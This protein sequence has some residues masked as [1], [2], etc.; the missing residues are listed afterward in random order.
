M[1]CVRE[2][3]SPYD[4]TVSDTLPGNTISHTQGV[5]AG[6]P[7]N[8]GYSSN[9]IAGIAPGQSRSSAAPIIRCASA[10]VGRTL[11]FSE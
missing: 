8:I 7:E 4:V 5:V 1:Q 9:A 6:R 11:T 2:V 10:I 3:Y